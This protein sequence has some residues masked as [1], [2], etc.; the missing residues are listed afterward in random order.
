[1]QVPVMALLNVS[2]N[3]MSSYGHTHAV[4]FNVR[5]TIANISEEDIIDCFY[6]GITNPGIYR[7]F[8]QNRE[9]LLQDFMT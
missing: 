5:A 4:F 6:N 7:D 1:M 2:R 8:G 9:K 3:V